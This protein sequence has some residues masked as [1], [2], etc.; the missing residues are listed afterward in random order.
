MEITT[1]GPYII[2]KTLGAGANGLY[3]TQNFR[4]SSI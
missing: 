4:K 2:G 3:R 1:V